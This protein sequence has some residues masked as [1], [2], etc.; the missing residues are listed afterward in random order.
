M[1]TRWVMI[2]LFLLFIILVFV[3]NRTEAGP[4]PLADV[5][6]AV[7]AELINTRRLNANEKFF[8][9][10]LSHY[11]VTIADVPATPAKNLGNK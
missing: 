11:R 3:S 9:G 1:I 6:D 8:E 2:P 5:R 4:R 7:R 10:L